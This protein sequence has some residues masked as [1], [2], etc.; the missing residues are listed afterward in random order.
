M[1]FYTSVLHVCTNFAFFSTCSI[2]RTE[3]RVLHELLFFSCFCSLDN[4]CTLLF[5]SVR[6]SDFGKYYCMVENNGVTLKSQ[7]VSLF[8]GNLPPR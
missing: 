6:E 8:P 7:E 5:D 4:S 1:V 2:L 3:K